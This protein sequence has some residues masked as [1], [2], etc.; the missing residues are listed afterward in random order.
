MK[1]FYK[2]VIGIDEYGSN[3]HYFI[4]GKIYKLVSDT[5]DAI[6]LVDE[7]GDYHYIPLYI[8]ET[9]FKSLASNKRKRDDKERR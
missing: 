9:H 6:Y 2:C 1:K 8:F 5:E 4:I 3:I 7:L